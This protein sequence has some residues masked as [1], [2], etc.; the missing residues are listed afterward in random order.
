[1][2]TIV[3]GGQYGSEGKGKIAALL[4]ENIKNP[5]LVRCGG[6]NSGHTV[7]KEGKL[8]TLRQLSAS[9]N[10]ERTQFYVSAGCVIDVDRM[11][12]EIDQLG[13]HKGQLHID[14]RAIIMNEA[15]TASEKE[16]VTNIGSTGSGNG[17]A[18][19]RRIQRHQDNKFAGDEPRLTAKATIID[20]AD[21]LN[22]VIDSRDDVQVDKPEI[23]IEG[24]QGFGLS[25]LHCPHYPYCTSRDTSTSGFMSEVGL[26]GR[27]ITRA[28]M[29]IR[30]FPIRVGGPSGPLKDEITW[31][32]VA[33]IGGA[34]E[35]IN[36]F[37][38]VTNRLRRVGRFDLDEIKR[39]VRINRP[40]ELAVMGMDRLNVEDYQTSELSKFGQNWISDLEDATGVPVTFAGTGPGTGDV[41]RLRR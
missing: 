5:H 19:V 27:L 11:L 25:L 26:S 28:I 33:K 39:A 22:R 35:V 10:I 1:M 40:T 4:S 6:P 12:L 18:F 38:S 8:I 3:V 13:L 14:R 37:T 16:I 30:T 20:V 41:L 32:E 24:T 9:V 17:A 21:Y 7:T 23:F 34:G 36:E 2:V 29:V 31:E 15:D